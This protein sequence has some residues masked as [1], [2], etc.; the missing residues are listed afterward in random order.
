MDAPSLVRPVTR[1][2]DSSDSFSTSL[3]APRIMSFAFS[4]GT[5]LSISTLIS[6][7]QSCTRGNYSWSRDTPCVFLSFFLF[8][9]HNGRV[10]TSCVQGSDS[11]LAEYKHYT[12]IHH[13]KRSSFMFSFFSSYAASSQQSGSMCDCDRTCKQLQGYHSMCG[14]W[15]DSW[16]GLGHCHHCYCCSPSAWLFSA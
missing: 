5:G 13:N 16:L 11:W 10:P 8:C 7:T 9:L 14:M 4:H 3:S 2:D 6:T 15:L 12:T 1:R